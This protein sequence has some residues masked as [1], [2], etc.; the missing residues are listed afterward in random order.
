MFEHSMDAL[1]GH[2]LRGTSTGANVPMGRPMRAFS[3]KA[4]VLIPEHVPNM[5]QCSRYIMLR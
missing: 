3:M 5:H 4:E 1:T 2:A